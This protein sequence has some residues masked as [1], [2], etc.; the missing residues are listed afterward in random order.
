MAKCNSLLSCCLKHFSDLQRTLLTRG[1]QLLAP[2][3]KEICKNARNVTTNRNKGI[4]IQ[5]KVVHDEFGN[6]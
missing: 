1:R 2:F 6:D 4:K 3:S 5:N